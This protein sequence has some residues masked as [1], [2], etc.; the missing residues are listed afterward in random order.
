MTVA[1][2][3]R[4]EDGEWQPRMNDTSQGCRNGEFLVAAVL[5]AL[6]RLVVPYLP[7]RR[8]WRG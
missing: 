1:W 6:A 8:L 3:L 2:W 5:A 7:K 4:E